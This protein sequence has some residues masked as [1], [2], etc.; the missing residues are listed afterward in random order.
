VKAPAYWFPAKARGWGW[1]LPRI[2]QGW[3]VLI[4]FFV[5]VAVGAAVLL[6][7]LGQWVFVGYCALLCLALVGVC[8]V[9]GEPPKWR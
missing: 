6:P 9:K 5:L 7:K 1:G 4:V 3:L 8:F 2:W